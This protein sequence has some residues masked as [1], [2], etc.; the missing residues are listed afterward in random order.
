[1]DVQ[2]GTLEFRG[3]G[4][5]NHQ[6]ALTVAEFAKVSF[7]Y[8]AHV[9]ASGSSINDTA[10][11]TLE[12]G[13]NTAVTFNQ[14][15][16][17]AA[18]Q[19]TSS[20][21]VTVNANVSVGSYTHTNGTLNGTANLTVTGS[22]VLANGEHTGSGTTIFDTGSTVSHSGV[23]YL[24][25]GRKIINRGTYSLTGNGYW[26]ARGGIGSPVGTVT[27][28][29]GG[30]WTITGTRLVYNDNSSS[31]AFVNAGTLIKSGVGTTSF[32]TSSGQSTFT[33]NG[34]FEVQGGSFNMGT[35]SSLTFA[36]GSTTKL[37][38]GGQTNNKVIDGGAAITFGGGIQ[39][40]LS[41][42]FAPTNGQ[43]ITLMDYGS[44]TGTSPLTAPGGYTSLTPTYNAT[45]LE[46]TFNQ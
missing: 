12:S 43:T 1:V 14:A 24:E 20:D 9:F 18:L 25:S 27:N 22:A 2:G 38:T 3:S 35:A 6:G 21:T 28:A 34:T 15:E 45:N 41:A 13:G 37:T 39:V 26:Y 29:A 40:L 4:G 17:L 7:R 31:I 16:T 30:T 32:G 5:G 36:G 44:R 11:L 10:T 42:G 8:G 33:N 46:V 19:L 23:I